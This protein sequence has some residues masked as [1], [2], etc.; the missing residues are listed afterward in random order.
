MP[1]LFVFLLK[2]NIALL[3]FCAGYFLV[4]RHLTFYTLN[5]IYLVA[6][7]VFASV[8]PKIDLNNFAERHQALSSRVQTVI[9]NFQ[10]PAEALVKPISQPTYWD[11]AEIAFWCG[12]LILAIRLLMQLFSL[13]KL[14]RNSIPMNIKDHQ[15]RVMHGDAAPFSFWRSIYVNPANHEPSDLKAI[16]QH[17][18]IHVNE[19][20][21][22]DILLA[23]L[24]TIFYWFNPGIWLMKKAVRENIE[25][26]TDRKILRGGMDS[27]DYQYSLVNVSFS[28]APQTIVNNF[29]LSTIKKR[30]IMMNAKRSSKFN[31]TRYAVLVPLVL[32]CLLSFSFSRAELVKKS[33][34]V[35][36]EI[37]AS[38]NKVDI[39]KLVKK[40]AAEVSQRIETLVLKNDTIKAGKPAT[41]KLS[42]SI[43]LND[44]IRKRGRD[45]LSEIKVIGYKLQADS[46]VR[47]KLLKQDGGNQPLLIING[48]TV[49]FDELSKLNPNV[50]DNIKVE[51]NNNDS[52]GII[53]IDTKDGQPITAVRVNGVDYTKKGEAF[54]VRDTMVKVVVGRRMQDS[55]LFARARAYSLKKGGSGRISSVTVTSSGDENHDQLM[56]EHGVYSL[57]V[58]SA[59]PV[60]IVN[61][62]RSADIKLMFTKRRNESTIENL[63]SKLI[64]IDGKEASA[65]DM[66]KLPAADIKSM[67]VQS[68]DE[69]IKKYGEKAKEGVLFI[70][71]TKS[72]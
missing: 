6:A 57:S 41:L 58:D 30:I 49:K 48:K 14:H 69:V 17:E 12:A 43:M 24:S 51:K 27:K 37:A 40:N 19:W 7:I 47:L 13:Y 20:H 55:A 38:A 9:L 68:G 22:L 28:A 71:T 3:L 21:T 11:W 4:L 59:A 50:I 45:S 64:F 66:K 25:F 54:V 63:S 61:A 16:L 53:Y 52:R 10:Q 31:L 18:Q 26:I 70:T 56:N 39:I 42:Y 62:K 8:Y 72:K 65:K 29:N 32:V 1:A 44:T 36:K 23:E 33:T 15:V 5:R 2:V 46:L 67:N 60:S 35:Y 34:L